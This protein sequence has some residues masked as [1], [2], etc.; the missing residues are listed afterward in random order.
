MMKR[1][2][3]MEIYTAAKGKKGDLMA[4]TKPTKAKV[5]IALLHKIPL[6]QR[7]KFKE[8]TL[9]MARNIELTIKKLF[10]KHHLGHRPF[11]CSE[12]GIKRIAEN[13]DE[14][15]MGIARY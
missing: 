7:K 1:L 11:P 15:Q 13:Q 8:V 6:K 2:L 10:S 9:N 14:P 3:T 4:M 5:I 12:T